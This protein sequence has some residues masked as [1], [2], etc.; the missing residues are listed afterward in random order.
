M[1][2]HGLL[3]HSTFIGR[4]NC[5][6]KERISRYLAYKC[7]IASKIDC[8]SGIVIYTYVLNINVRIVILLDIKVLLLTNNHF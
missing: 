5:K 7:S 6:D 4:A 2:K 1:P 8:F 3:F